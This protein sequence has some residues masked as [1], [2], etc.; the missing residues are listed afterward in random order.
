MHPKT[1]IEFD[2]ETFARMKRDIELLSKIN[3]GRSMSPT[4]ATKL[5]SKDR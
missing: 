1:N 5:S 2:Q 4:Y 3:R